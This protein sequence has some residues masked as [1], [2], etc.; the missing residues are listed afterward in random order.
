MYT[1][2]T[3]YP[4]ILKEIRL[5]LQDVG[6]KLQKHVRRNKKAAEEAKKRGYIEKFIPHIGIALRE[7]LDLS[8]GQEEDVVRTLKDVLERSRK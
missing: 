5:A 2:G 7:I 3:R 4:E 8:E 1:Y 6:R